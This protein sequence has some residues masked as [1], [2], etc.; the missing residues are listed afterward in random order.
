MSLLRLVPR[1][2]HTSTCPKACFLGSNT[3]YQR[4]SLCLHAAIVDRGRATSTLRSSGVD[5]VVNERVEREGR[6]RCATAEV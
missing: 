6:E 3:Q 4:Q 2:T 1:G 5:R